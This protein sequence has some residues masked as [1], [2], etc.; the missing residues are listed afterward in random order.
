[1]TVR[2]SRHVCRVLA[3]AAAL[4]GATYA[5]QAS[6]VV[7]FTVDYALDEVDDN[8]GNLSCHT[9][10]NH[11]TLRA[12][13]M[14]ATLVPNDDT[15]IVVPAGTYGLTIPA[16]AG[17]VGDGPLKVPPPAMGNPTLSILGAGAGATIIDIGASLRAFVVSRPARIVGMTI[18]GGRSQAASC[19]CGAKFF[20]SRFFV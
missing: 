19:C 20:E 14:E 6:A 9:A 12:A 1:M 10:T 13:V 16:G 2:L 15:V 11:C 5:P 4:A 8:P 18:R 7:V 3:L 17:G